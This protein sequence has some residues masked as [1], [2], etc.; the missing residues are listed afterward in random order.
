MQRYA[1]VED[2]GTI[3]LYCTVQY[4]T[5]CAK[6]RNAKHVTHNSR[7]NKR[8]HPE[9]GCDVS[10]AAHTTHESATAHHQC[11]AA[12]NNAAKPASDVTALWYCVQYFSI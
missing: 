3:T 4:P 5:L 10:S 2:Q 8:T 9:A 11:R 7:T 12:W 1:L 6:Q